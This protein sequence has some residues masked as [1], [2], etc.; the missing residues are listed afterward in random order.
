M[1]VAGSRRRWIWIGGAAALV[2]LVAAV[3]TVVLVTKGGDGPSERFEQAAKVFHD[4]YGPLS[5]HMTTSLRQAGGGFGDR[6]YLEAQQDAKQLGEAF[7]TYGK[8]LAAIAFPEGAKAAVTKLTDATRAGQVLM[9]NAAGFFSKDQ[10]QATL[11]QYQPQVESAIT[12]DEKAL[13][14]ALNPR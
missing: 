7:D 9:V 12:N 2:V 8:A 1:V 4:R 11:E 6:K 10:M 3:V 13:R 5:T 14:A